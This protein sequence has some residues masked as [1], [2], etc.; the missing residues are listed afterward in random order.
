MIYSYRL[1]FCLFLVHASGV[2]LGQTKKDSLVSGSFLNLKFDKFAKEL[3]KQT[4]Y[5][6][7]FDLKSTD[8]LIVNVTVGQ[9]TIQSVL[10]QIFVDTDFHYAMDDQKN[11]YIVRGIT[12]Q[13]TLPDAFNTV[14]EGVRRQFDVDYLE[15][16]NKEK[17]RLLLEI[18]QYDIGKKTTVVGEGNAIIAG[19]VKS[20][21]TGESIIGAS[22]Y[23]TDPLIGVTSDQFGYF[24]ITLPKGKH[25]LHIRSGGMKQAVRKVMVYAD[26]KLN[27][28]LL[29]DVIT[30]KEV[31]VES[32]KDKNVSGDQMGVQRLDIKTM[33]KLAMVFGEVDVLKVMLTLP[34]VQ[35]VGEGTTG[36]NVRGG[37]TS[38]NLILFDD[39]TI[40]NPAHLFG[41]FSAFNPDVIKNVELY[42]SSIPAEFGGRLSSV[43]DVNSREGNVKKF[44]GAGGIGPVTGRLTLEGPILKNKVSYLIGGRTTYSDWLLKKIPSDALKNSQASFYDL[45]AKVQAEINEKN[46]LYV[47]GYFSKDRFRLNSDTA[48]SYTSKAATLKWKHSFNN[49]L[50]GVLTGGYS[51][52]AY[53]IGSNKNP[54]DAF[55]LL[56]AIHQTSLKM[57]FNYFPIPKHTINMGASVIK[58]LLS[59]GSK[60][61]SDLA[62]KDGNE[63][64][65]NEQGL[66][67]AVYI[68]DHF[69]ASPRL[70]IYGGLRY[71]YYNYL[72]PHDVYHYE[73]G[74]SRSVSTIVDTVSYKSGKSIASYGGPEYR[75]SVKYGIS[76][77]SS[78]K[79]SYNRTRQYIQMLTNTTAI[80]PTDTW[81]LSD[82]YIRPQVGDQ[83]SLGFYKNLRGNLIEASFETY[84]KTMANSIDYKSGAKLLLNHSIETDIIRAQGKAFGFEFMVKKTAGKMNG[85]VTYTYSRSL[86]RTKGNFASETVNGGNYY[87]SN[88]DKPHAVNLIGNYK[89]S[90]RYSTS[91][92]F[93]YSTGRPIT[94]PVAKYYVDGSYRTLYGPRNGD[95]VPDYLRVDIFVNIEGNHRI[96]KPAHASWTI[97]VYNLTGRRNAYSV[98]YESQNGK[99][100][101][102]KLSVLG[103]AMPSITYNFKF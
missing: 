46:S 74:E 19:Y 103:S 98:F 97:G 3:E 77:G 45:N 26:G 54:V 50:Y 9:K 25:E 72:G 35:S 55:T 92:N 11:I 17:S 12:I 91:L 24:A 96:N 6:F 33:K 94:V 22:V 84:Y 70:S 1:I 13:S 49:K 43:L 40:Y 78:V 58:Y 83:I 48:Y 10:D 69:E 51:G 47:M 42:K 75:F 23:V 39:A 34:G 71:S 95:R 63:I 31:V 28:E 2:T 37:A 32:D 73:A 15:T 60:I 100:H 85:W 38:Q 41:F 87:P 93:T 88:Y 81:K 82:S 7:F 5:K 27:V 21:V 86:L 61:N 53:Q 89:F 8:S 29:E 59:P 102:Y 36:L 18:K 64:L 62:L 101:G 4:P 66:E 67:S 44:S 68:G 14:A 56:Y 57:D 16:E 52:Y 99:I 65:P 79:L 90:H 80:S 30:L 20:A 76:E